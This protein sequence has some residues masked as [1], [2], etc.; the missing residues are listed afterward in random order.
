MQVSQTLLRSSLPQMNGI[1]VISSPVYNW[2]K[3]LFGGLCSNTVFFYLLCH[4]PSS[5][6][7]LFGYAE[8]VYFR[9]AGGSTHIAPTLLK[10]LTCFREGETV[11]RSGQLRDSPHRSL[12]DHT[13]LHDPTKGFLKL[14]LFCLKYAQ[15]TSKFDTQSLKKRLHA[16]M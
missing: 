4:L 12:Y 16:L 10:V 8:E 15:R 9:E 2:C 3:H 11:T 5:N 7:H 14:N 13:R 6:C 1:V